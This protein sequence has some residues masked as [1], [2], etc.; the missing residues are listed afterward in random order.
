MR[1]V[2]AASVN[3]A[4]RVP[5]AEI[6]DEAVERL[7]KVM[8]EVLKPEDMRNGTTKDTTREERKGAEEVL[9]HDME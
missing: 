8:D 7:A 2:L 3:H 4:D 9:K 5:A 6:S 1:E